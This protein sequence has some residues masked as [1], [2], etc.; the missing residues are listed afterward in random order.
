MP[1]FLHELHRVYKPQ[2]NMMNPG[3]STHSGT[4]GI[5]YC[6]ST[7]PVQVNYWAVI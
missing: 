1:V 5:Y 4:E 6:G 3:L 2:V 7:A